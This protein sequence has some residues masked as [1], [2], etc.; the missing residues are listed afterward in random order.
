MQ[1]C[2]A[3]EEVSQ[4]G[5]GLISQFGRQDHMIRLNAAFR[6]DLEWWHIFVGSWNGIFMM[7]K[8]S[9][10]TPGV[11]IWSDAF[12]SWGCGALW[13]TQWFQVAWCEW[14]GFVTASIAA[15][16]LLPIIVATAI[17][18]SGWEG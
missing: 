3:R 6:A 10:Q 11:E 9:W 8:E 16:E 18:G 5:F 13:G 1:S 17:W 14:P 12:G 2:K 4:G 7:L 15:K